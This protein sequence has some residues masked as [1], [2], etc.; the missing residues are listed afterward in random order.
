MGLEPAP[1][2][3]VMGVQ[4]CG[5]STLGSLLAGELGVPFVDGDDLHPERN[6]TLMASGTPLSDDDR[7]PWLHAVGQQLADGGADG[8]VVACSALRQ[9]YRDLLREYAP[10]VLFVHPYGPKELV[11]ARI[12]LREHEYMP[13]SLLDS[14]YAALEH[15]DEAEEGTTLD[16]GG[17]PLELV[18][19]AVTFVDESRIRAYQQD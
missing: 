6:R 2:V 17:P 10:N 8:I 3:V 11:A 15:L 18:S 19:S 14:Q 13:P 1:V 5:K 7:Q 12:S 16:L 4:G 9:A